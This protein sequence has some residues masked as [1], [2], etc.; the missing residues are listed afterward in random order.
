M[1]HTSKVALL[2]YILVQSSRRGAPP[3]SSVFYMEVHRVAAPRSSFEVMELM[4]AAHLQGCVAPL[5]ARTEY[6]L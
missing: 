5:Y 1:Q 2:P 3:I 6:G 4:D